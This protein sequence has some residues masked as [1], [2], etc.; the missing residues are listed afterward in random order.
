MF[1]AAALDDA[2]AFDDASEES[3]ALEAGAEGRESVAEADE[4]ATEETT[5]SSAA[6]EDRLDCTDDDGAMRI[7]GT[8]GTEETS[9]AKDSAEE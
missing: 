7:G 4:R 8:C 3:C 5:G 2:G 9:M 1:A 6:F